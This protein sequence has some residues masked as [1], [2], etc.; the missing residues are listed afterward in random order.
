MATNLAKLARTKLK[1]IITQKYLP[2]LSAKTSQHLFHVNGK[3]VPILEFSKILK[4]SSGLIPQSIS[5][6]SLRDAIGRVARAEFGQL[7]HLKP[8]GQTSQDQPVQPESTQGP[9]EVRLR[10]DLEQA[11]RVH[12]VIQTKDPE[13]QVV[14]A[15]RDLDFQQAS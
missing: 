13:T 3:N 10:L 7:R 14:Q 8:R 2:E 4:S 1:P 11:G 9:S 15:Y 5:E 12:L 6:E